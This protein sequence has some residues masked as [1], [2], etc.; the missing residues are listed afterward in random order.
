[1]QISNLAVVLYSSI[2]GFLQAK[3]KATV[4]TLTIYTS[5]FN[6]ID[7]NRFITYSATIGIGNQDPRKLIDK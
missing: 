4:P 1:M 2:P 6:T 3:N 5:T 7:I